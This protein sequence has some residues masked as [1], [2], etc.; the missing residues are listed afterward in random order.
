MRKTCTRKPAPLIVD[1]ADSKIK[2]LGN[3]ALG[4]NSPRKEQEK[5]RFISDVDEEV[6][7]HLQIHPSLATNALIEIVTGRL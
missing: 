2:E 6:V 7:A 5:C 4:D 1:G 3:I